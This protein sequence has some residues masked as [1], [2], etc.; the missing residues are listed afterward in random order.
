MIILK[1]VRY[2]ITDLKELES[3]LAHLDETTSKVPGV[4]LR[5]IYFPRNEEEFIL[6]LDCISEEKYLEWREICPPPSGVKDW[7]EVLLTKDEHFTEMN[8]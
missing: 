5:D 4:A 1:H 6:D 7:Y 3:L 2:E 8:V